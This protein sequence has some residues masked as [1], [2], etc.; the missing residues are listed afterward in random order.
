MVPDQ[1]QS[2]LLERVLNLATRLSILAVPLIALFF[3]LWLKKAKEKESESWP[4]VSGRIVSAKVQRIE[5]STRYAASLS[6][7]YFVGGYESGTHEPSFSNEDEAHAFVR[8]L[9]DREVLVRYNDKKP[10]DSLIE[11]RSIEQIVLTTPDA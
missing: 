6:Y 9:K 5:K 10:E 4:T 1:S 8:K 2:D 3:G 11:K 7:A